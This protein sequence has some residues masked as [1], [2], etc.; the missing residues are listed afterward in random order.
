[1]SENEKLQRE[2]ETYQRVFS[3]I[4]IPEPVDVETI[5]KENRRETGMNFW[6]KHAAALG[7]ALVI[8]GSTGVAYAA[9]LGGIRTTVNVWLH[10]EHTQLD[11]VPNGT[12]GYEFYET[13]SDEPIGGGGGVWID[14]NG[15]E[16]AASAQEVAENLA[17]PVE[18]REDGTVWLSVNDQTWDITDYI[19]S[20][21]AENFHAGS[22]YFRV[23]VEGTG[24]QTQTSDRP[25]PG[26]AYIEL[27]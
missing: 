26:I 4:Q 21:K 19:Q 10:G 20:G 24:V 7:A 23:L 17:S 25:E 18:V 12:G 5:M 2:R 3:K 22:R 13:G 9:D 14:E 1:M 11:A 8:A 15:V 16:H 27:D 6:Q